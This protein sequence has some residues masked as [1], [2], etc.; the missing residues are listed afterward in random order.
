[1][2]LKNPRF[3]CRSLPRYPKLLKGALNALVADER[4]I[5]G[6]EDLTHKTT[7][8][9]SFYTHRGLGAQ[10]SPIRPG[11][12]TPDPLPGRVLKNVDQPEGAA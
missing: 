5:D 12:V 4:T 11:V 7:A 9:T 3:L 2:P 6:P 10:A 1:M 8:Q